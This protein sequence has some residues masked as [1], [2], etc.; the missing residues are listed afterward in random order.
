M[1]SRT[2]D[3][4]VF[5]ILRDLWEKLKCPSRRLKTRCTADWA[6]SLA[7]FSLVYSNWRND[8]SKVDSGERKDIDSNVEGRPPLERIL[9]DVVTLRDDL[10]TIL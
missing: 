6:F 5:I 2:V 9:K 3:Y 1:R 8:E 10:F 4:C 7:S